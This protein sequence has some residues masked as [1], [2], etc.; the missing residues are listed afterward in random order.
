[1][2]VFWVDP[3]A[4]LLQDVPEATSSHGHQVNRVVEGLHV[5]DVVVDDLSNLSTESL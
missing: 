3:L 5:E 1:M 2:N 4:G